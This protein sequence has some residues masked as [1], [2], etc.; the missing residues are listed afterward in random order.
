[1]NNKDKISL[2][3]YLLK[4]NEYVRTRDNLTK[5]INEMY[6]ENEFVGNN[7]QQQRYRELTDKHNE[8]VIRLLE[9]YCKKYC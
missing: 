6:L 2:S 5:I 7:I 8:V 4:N 1:M 9:S 3:D